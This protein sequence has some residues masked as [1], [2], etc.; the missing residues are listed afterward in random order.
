MPAKP[1]PTVPLVRSDVWN[2]ERMAEPGRLRRRSRLLEKYVAGEA[3]DS[4]ATQASAI[5]AEIWGDR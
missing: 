1:R 4:E 5:L 2:E 3:S